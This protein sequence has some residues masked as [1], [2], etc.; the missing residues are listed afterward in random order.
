MLIPELHSLAMWL[1]TFPPGSRIRILIPWVWS[2][3]QL[4][5]LCSRRDKHAD[6]KPGRREYPRLSSLRILSR[7]SVAWPSVRRWHRAALGI[8]MV[9]PPIW[10]DQANVN[11]ADP[12]LMNVWPPGFSL[13]P[14]YSSDMNCPSE[15]HYKRLGFHAQNCEVE[16]GPWLYPWTPKQNKHLKHVTSLIITIWR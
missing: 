13:N 15:S 16:F 5:L 9:T 4:V 12:H 1:D 6:S 8:L 10:K 2:N 14:C 3:L 7:C 11:K